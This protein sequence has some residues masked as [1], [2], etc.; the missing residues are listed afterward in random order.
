ML[1]NINAGIYNLLDYTNGLSTEIAND[2][3]P[4]GKI[5]QVRLILGENNTVKVDGQTYSLSTPSSQQTGLKLQVNTTLKENISYSM[6][7]DFD[8]SQ[9]VVKA[10]NGSYILKPVIRV[11]TEEVDGAITG[12][13]IPSEVKPAILAISGDDTVG[14][15][16]DDQGNYLI[17]GL[18]AGK[19]KVVVVPNSSYHKT[20]INDVDVSL[21]TVTDMGEISLVVNN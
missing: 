21:G 2:L 20:E 3:F 9:S 1:H 15:Y 14:T 11:I 7:L 17:K 6:L 10:G 18:K 19:Y 8:A 5:T 12:H 4:V 13:I 16:A